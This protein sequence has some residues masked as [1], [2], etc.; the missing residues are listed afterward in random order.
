MQVSARLE[1]RPA[2][3][4]DRWG[5]VDDGEWRPSARSG[6]SCVSTPR[7]V[8]IFGGERAN[9]RAAPHLYMLDIGATLPHG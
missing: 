2:K 1:Q 4:L 6:H 8:A 9:G 5:I 7:G 3:K